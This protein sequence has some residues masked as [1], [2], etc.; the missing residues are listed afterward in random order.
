METR[1]YLFRKLVK[2]SRAAKYNMK[3]I[4]SLIEMSQQQLLYSTYYIQI[5]NFTFSIV[6]RKKRRNFFIEIICIIG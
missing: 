4:L 3:N 5:E 6:N 2:R 1:G